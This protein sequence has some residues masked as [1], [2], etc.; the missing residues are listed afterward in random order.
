MRL[1]D[2]VMLS[3]VEAAN[4]SVFDGFV[5]CNKELFLIGKGS[6]EQQPACRVALWKTET[7]R[8]TSQ[9]VR[10]CGGTSILLRHM[11]YPHHLLALSGEGMTMGFCPTRRGLRLLV[12][13]RG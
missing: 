5:V 6:W 11:I 4:L 13:R 10:A 7:P 3:R 12:V 1:L 2:V 8:T 9:I